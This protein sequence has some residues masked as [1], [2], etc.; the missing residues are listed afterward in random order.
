MSV[1]IDKGIRWPDAIVSQLGTLNLGLTCLTPENLEEPW[2][3]VPKQE[4]FPGM[5][6]VALGLIWHEFAARKYQPAAGCNSSIPRSST[7]ED[8]FKLMRSINGL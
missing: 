5:Q 1:D 4:R 6:M 8:T 2:L 3:A 7:R